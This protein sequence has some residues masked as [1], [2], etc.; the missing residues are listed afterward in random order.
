MQAWCALL[1]ASRARRGESVVMHQQWRLSLLDKCSC[2]I[3]IFQAKIR[4]VLGGAD[5]QLPR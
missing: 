5:L 4:F 1:I 3:C 2:F